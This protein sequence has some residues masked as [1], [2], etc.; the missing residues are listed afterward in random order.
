M[1]GFILK[2]YNFDINGKEILL[3]LIAKYIVRSPL[4]NRCDAS[5]KVDNLN[6]AKTRFE[7]DYYFILQSL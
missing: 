3:Q 7:R 4:S 2:N 1:S 5:G 6:A